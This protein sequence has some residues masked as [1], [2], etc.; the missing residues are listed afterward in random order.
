MKLRVCLALAP[1]VLLAAVSS[2]SSAAA[3][4]KLDSSATR[5]WQPWCVR[6]P[7]LVCTI[8]GTG[9]NSGVT[10]TL[11]FSNVR[12]TAHNSWRRWGRRGRRCR[13]KVTGS[14]QGLSPG[15]HGL[16][17]HSFGDERATSGSSLGPHFPNPWFIP[18][19][20]GLPNDRQRHWGDFGNFVAD[21]SGVARVD[22][23]DRLV[24]LRGIVGRGMVIH[25]GE[26]KGAAFQPSGA[27][28]PRMGTC[29]IGYANPDL[30]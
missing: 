7:K 21:T 8:R 28:G 4:D 20:H 5:R 2:V 6:A 13:V 1:I 15:K 17:I 23:V 22:Y 12:D 19:P 11:V 9:S 30:K 27:S 29:V 14:I 24:T 26:D 3:V 10:G 18:T 16:H 25:G